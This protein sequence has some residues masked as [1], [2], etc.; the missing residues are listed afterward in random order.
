MYLYHYSKEKYNKILTK[1]RQKVLSKDEIKD[2]EE[3]AKFRDDVGLYC[4]HISLFFDPI[5]LDI[6]ADLFNNEHPFWYKG[7]ELYQYK[8]N[9]KYFETNITYK[10][11]ESPESVS[12]LD[13]TGWEE[14]DDW[15]YKWFR[16]RNQLMDKLGQRGHSRADLEKQC[17][18]FFGT[19]RDYYKK[20]VNRSDFEEN[21][22]LYAA[23]VP[24]IAVYPISG[25]INPESVTKVVIG[26]KLA[27]ESNQVLYKEW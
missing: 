25:I 8:V 5:P 21:K 3:G 6:I 4:D 17:Q 10:V 7:N 9:T 22:T 14:D 16:E 27:I 13:K 24:H 15:K 12:F 26:R 19:T 18:R 23:S 20:A 2:D 1:R 11:L